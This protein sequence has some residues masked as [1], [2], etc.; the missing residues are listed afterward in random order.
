MAYRSV[1]MVVDGA[2]MTT[3]TRSSISVAAPSVGR[4]PARVAVA[5][6]GHGLRVESELL[7]RLEPEHL[8]HAAPRGGVGRVRADTRRSIGTRLAQR[9]RLTKVRKLLQRLGVDLPYATRR[10]AIAGLR[11]GRMAPNGAG[12]RLPTREEASSTRDG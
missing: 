8:L 2:T 3:A 10:V 12:G 6:S 9:L 5:R 11:F 4:S 1:T 7:R